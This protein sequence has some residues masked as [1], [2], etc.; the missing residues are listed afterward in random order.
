MGSL[1]WPPDVAMNTDLQTIALAWRG[2][3]KEREYLIRGM[4]GAQGRTLD[5]SPPDED[6]APV[7]RRRRGTMADRF[8]MLAQQHNAWFTAQRRRPGIRAPRA[9]KLTPRDS[10]G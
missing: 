5:P 6:D 2:H 4:Y 9:P 3:V 8:K 1:G 10:E 7:E